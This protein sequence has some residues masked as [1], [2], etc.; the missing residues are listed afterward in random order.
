MRGGVSH[1]T[2][3]NYEAG[4]SEPVSDNLASIKT[5]LEAAGVVFLAPDG[6]GGP[7]VRLLTGRTGGGRPGR[8]G[9]RSAAV[10]SASEVSAAPAAS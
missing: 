9:R 3:R 7:P 10:A 1:S 2:V 5:E 4:R 8:S 6:K